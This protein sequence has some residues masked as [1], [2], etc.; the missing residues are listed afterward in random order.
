MTQY[1]PHT[2]KTPS[3][4]LCV[5]AL[6]YLCS[7]IFASADPNDTII[8]DPNP[9]V[10][11]A[12]VG[13]AVF[14]DDSNGAFYWHAGILWF[15]DGYKN[16]YQ[17]IQAT[18]IGHKLEPVNWQTFLKS[19][20]YQGARQHIDHC[21]PTTDQQQE[22]IYQAQFQVNASFTFSAA[23]SDN[24][25]NNRPNSDYQSGDGRFRCDQ[26]VE[27]VYATTYGTELKPGI[28]LDAP[29]SILD[30]ADNA[31]PSVVTP[32]T[33]AQITEP[34]SPNASIVITFSELMSRGTITPQTITLTNAA[35]SPC[36]FTITY[37]SDPLRHR[38]DLFVDPQGIRH[39]CIAVII[40]PD[41]PL[42]IN[43]S[44]TLTLTPNIRDL[45]GN[46][47]TQPHSH[48][49]TITP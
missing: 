44:I 1:R 4:T 17:V 26:F 31:I 32:P 47:L 45:A 12:E 7:A 9:S 46:P 40:T 42:P 10:I 16:E 43:E 27:Y 14:R 49:F 11:N 24:W 22:I 25:P 38:D 8:S 41:Q 39:D 23:W 28:R 35:Q 29:F 5:I 37:H 33:V 21:P 6:L 36:V 13:D 48:T 20:I 30:Y 2:I 18:G 3:I 19:A 34:N 15:Y